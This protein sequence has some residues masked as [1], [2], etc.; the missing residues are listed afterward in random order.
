MPMPGTSSTQ[1]FHPSFH[2]GWGEPHF[3]HKALF[4]DFY[5]W[6][7]LGP[8]CAKLA[9]FSAVAAAILRRSPKNR[10]ILSASRLWDHKILGWLATSIARTGCRG[11]NSIKCS[12]CCAQTWFASCHGIATYLPH[13][14]SLV[15]AIESPVYLTE[16]PPANLF[17]T[18]RPISRTACRQAIEAFQF[19]DKGLSL[20]DWYMWCVQGE[21]GPALFAD[22]LQHKAIPTDK[23][24][25]NVARIPDEY[26]F[27]PRAFSLLSGVRQR[28]PR[29]RSTSLQ[30]SGTQPFS[31]LD[32]PRLKG[33]SAVRCCGG[34]IQTISKSRASS[35]QLQE[36]FGTSRLVALPRSSLR[37]TAATLIRWRMSKFQPSDLAS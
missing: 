10:A 34:S 9:R 18:Q 19:S 11:L 20:K 14:Q 6:L 22:Q 5:V 27:K 21:F 30:P 35:P 17:C 31:V 12:I 16:P 2:K 24:I 15:H 23:V 29:I 7:C 28:W 4:A 1:T 33:H 25:Q 26:P 8:K 32:Q 36:S 3:N 37:S 13:L